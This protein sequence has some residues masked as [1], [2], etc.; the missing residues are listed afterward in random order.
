MQQLRYEIQ[1]W[2]PAVDELE[3]ID[4]AVAAWASLVPD[5]D[6][7]TM[8]TALLLARATA[9]GRRHVDAAFAACDSSAGEFDVLATLLHA[10]DH[11]STPS[12]L[13]R[14]RAPRPWAVAFGRGPGADRRG[15][16]GALAL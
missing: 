6:V 7:A 2:A 11:T 14:D 10:P 9:L 8:R 12:E 5:L 16:A 3:H 13:A 4:R 15:A 1:A